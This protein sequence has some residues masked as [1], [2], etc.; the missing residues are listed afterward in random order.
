MRDLPNKQP[1]CFVCDGILTALAPNL[2]FEHIASFN[3]TWICDSCGARYSEN[4]EVEETPVTE[5]EATDVSAQEPDENKSGTKIADSPTEPDSQSTGEWREFNTDGDNE[6]DWSVDWGESQTEKVERNRRVLD[7]AGEMSVDWHAP[8]GAPLDQTDQFVIAKTLYKNQFVLLDVRTG[9]LIDKVELVRNQS[10]TSAD[11]R[12][13]CDSEKIPDDIE[14]HP[15]GTFELDTRPGWDPDVGVHWC[16]GPN[17]LYTFDDR[18]VSR[19]PG[20]DAGSTWT[21]EVPTNG[22]SED[23]RC[24]AFL[25][26]VLLI[27]TTEILCAI[28]A[29]SGEISWR[30]KLSGGD[31]DDFQLL[32]H[33]DTLYLSEG[34]KLAALDVDSG[35][36]NWT[37]ELGD[38][39]RDQTVTQFGGIEGGVL[40]AVEKSDTNYVCGYDVASG[41]QRWA[42]QDRRRLSILRTQD[43]AVYVDGGDGVVLCLNAATGILR[44]QH[45]LKKLVMD[46]AKSRTRPDRGYI[47]FLETTDQAVVI[48]NWSGTVYLLDIETGN[49]Q[50]R[51]FPGGELPSDTGPEAA[52]RVVGDAVVRI[53]DTQIEAFDLSSG[54]ERWS[55][56][57]NEMVPTDT[58]W[59]EPVVE[60]DLLYFTDY[61]GT[62]YEVGP[63]AKGLQRQY[64]SEND[65]RRS[66]AVDAEH[67]YMASLEPSA[68]I[69]AYRKAQ[70]AGT[71]S[72]HSKDSADSLLNLHALLR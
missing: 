23:P 68:D 64:H 36:E 59:G 15:S 13:E 46:N 53:K 54:E 28:Q 65:G 10:G 49:K 70:K 44:W 5:Q 25:D 38:A 1:S 60:D 62:L 41:E 34:S 14:L 55:F 45:Q 30:H 67:V 61:D 33:P 29:G 27:A 40:L 32:L 66:F 6:P 48:C 56:E 31:G 69:P 21:V 51:S 7:N 11:D 20:S 19:H 4:V 43:G 39:H 24:C 2:N 63:E 58:G 26:G 42:F 22:E 8:F 9:D 35:V 52:C 16:V 72:T 50:W 47:D 37:R 3:R 12:Q 57:T 18:G 71:D 17:A